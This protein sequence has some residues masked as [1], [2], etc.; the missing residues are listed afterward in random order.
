MLTNK[1]NFIFPLLLLLF[2]ISNGCKKIVTVESPQTQLSSSSIFNSDATAIAAQLSIYSQMELDGLAYNIMINSGMSADEFTN[3]SSSVGAIDIATN[4][5]TPDNFVVQTIWARFYSYIYQANAILEGLK[6]A[7]KISDSTRKQLEGESKFVRAFCHFYLTSI[8]G[9]IP[10]INNTNYLINEK[11]ER[12]SVNSVYAFL[13]NDLKD[14][15]KLLGSDYLNARNSVSN[16]RVRPNKSTASALLSRIYLY[17]GKWSEAEIEASKVIELTSKY[18]LTTSLNNSFLKNNSEAIWQLFAVYPTY[19]SHPGAQLILRSTPT[20][21]ALDTNF[22]KSFRLSDNRKLSWIQSITVSGKTYY[23]PYKYKVGLNASTITEY[24]MV[25]RLSEQYLIR[26]EARAKLNN[27]N[28][29]LADLN[30]IR[31]RAGLTGLS[32]ISQTPLID[33]IQIER[34]YE[35]FSEFGDRWFNLRR[36][37]SINQ[38]MKNVKGNNWTET[39]QLYPIPQSEINRNAR[40]KQN[41]GY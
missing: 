36:T 22:V 11:A 14:A 13:E 20:V 19:N 6:Q 35:L 38:I 7:T 26:A 16:E 33:S 10:I 21:V 37:G 31:I 5:L 28:G 9:D 34:K 3:Y 15:V 30:Q 29:S 12:A 23:Y 27:I 8:Y 41:P 40:L 4:N 1:I 24:T 25:L 39:D 2:M 17:N 18:S 32:G